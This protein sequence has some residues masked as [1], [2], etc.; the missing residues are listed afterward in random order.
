MKY[1]LTL[2]LISAQSIG[3]N[4]KSHTP[5]TEAEKPPIFFLEKI[6]M[7]LINQEVDYP[8]IALAQILLE[9][10][11]LESDLC[12]TAYNLFGMKLP[13][14]RPTTAIGKYKGHAVYCSWKSSIADYRLWQKYHQKYYN[15][16]QSY[17]S[18]IGNR[19]AT[20][21]NYLKKLRI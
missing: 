2:L 8:K 18:F 16:Y 14:V 7:E 17:I 20:D 10:G 15:S 6:R 12:W 5:M 3:M 11:D 19:Y 4:Y 1:L 13:R 21:P 9:T